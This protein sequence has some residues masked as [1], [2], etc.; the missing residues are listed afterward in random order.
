MQ[1]KCDECTKLNKQLEGQTHVINAIE[2]ELRAIREEFA[3]VEK[4]VGCNELRGE[5]SSTM[6]L[7]QSPCKS[8]LNRFLRVHCSVQSPCQIPAP[9]RN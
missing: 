9:C 3:S 6:S 8:W 5:C 7:S 1:A 4:A 2:E